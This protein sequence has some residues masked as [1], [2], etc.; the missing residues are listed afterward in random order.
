MR[1]IH[2]TFKIMSNM[3]ELKNSISWALNFYDKKA[4]ESTSLE[5]N[6]MRFMFSST[7]QMNLETR[8]R[9][10]SSSKV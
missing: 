8:K 7:L 9:F 2:A 6:R 1:N 10:F 4:E 5:I 3:N